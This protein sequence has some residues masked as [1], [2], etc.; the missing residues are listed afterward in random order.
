MIPN[1]KV[2][3][4]E[5]TFCYLLLLL[6]C[7]LHTSGTSHGRSWSQ[8]CMCPLKWK[9][10][11]VCVQWADGGLVPNCDVFCFKKG[12][13]LEGL[14]VCRRI[15]LKWSWGNR[16]TLDY[17]QWT[18]GGLV[19]PYDVFYLKKEADHLEGLVCGRIILKWLW[20]NRMWECEFDSCGTG[21]VPVVC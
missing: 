6:H 3:I 14:L 18:D 10:T 21:M 11:L 8:I 16:I 9:D 7:L 20:R 17:I 1:I 13:H 15:I 2:T 4:T 5:W 12:D 19:P